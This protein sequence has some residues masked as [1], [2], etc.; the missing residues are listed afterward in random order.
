M[1][2]L[3]VH[4]LSAPALA[5]HLCVNTL[6]VECE[7][8]T[9]DLMNGEQMREAYKKI[10][11][12]GKVP[13]LVDGDFS[14]SESGA[15]MRYLARREKSAL[16]PS[17]LQGRATAEQWMDFVAH[18]IR[19]P[20]SRVQFNR[21]FAEKFG[22][23]KDEASIAFGLHILSTT[24]PVIEAEIAAQGYVGRSEIGLADILLLATLDPAE[25]IE[26]DLSPYPA[27]T[28]WRENL[29]REKFYTDIHSHFGAEIG[30]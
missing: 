23:E 28:T 13:A 7:V 18:H 3:Y 2:T 14:V 19:T 17:D 21:M 11:P 24:L 1:L 22:Q 29:R 27:L 4:P 16:Y 6:G 30:L 9:V 15:I 25:I 26:V 8:K 12:Y 20:F 5:A 10:N